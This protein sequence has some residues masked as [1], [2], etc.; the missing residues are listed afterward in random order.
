M[1]FLSLLLVGVPW[2][3]IDVAL[4]SLDVYHHHIA[5]LFSSRPQP[6]RVLRHNVGVQRRKKGKQKCRPRH[7]IKMGRSARRRQRD[8]MQFDGWACSPPP[9]PTLQQD[10]IHYN[11]H[12]INE[13]IE[14]H[15]PSRIM[16]YC[17]VLCFAPHINTSSSNMPPSPGHG[18]DV[19]ARS[20]VPYPSTTLGD[21]SRTTSSCSSP[22]L[23][24]MLP[25]VDEILSAR[26]PQWTKNFMACNTN[27]GAQK[28]GCLLSLS[29]VLST[30]GEYFGYIPMVQT[31]GEGRANHFTKIACHPVYKLLFLPADNSN[32]SNY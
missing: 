16:D 8:V 14:S 2:W 20:V 5:H 24:P 23:K 1:F 27:F 10:S 26:G 6:R 9:L 7:T 29:S 12:D 22:S 17:K 15:D 13:L 11:E 21:Q 4:S 18:G 28:F 30:F 31:K 19:R 3:T 25:F 32:R